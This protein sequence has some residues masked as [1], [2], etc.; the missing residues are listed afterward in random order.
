MWLVKTFLP[1]FGDRWTGAMYCVSEC[2]SVSIWQ[3]RRRVESGMYSAADTL[4]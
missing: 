1:N 2:C 3:S 4:L